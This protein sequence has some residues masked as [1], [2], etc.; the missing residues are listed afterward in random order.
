MKRISFFLVLFFMLVLYSSS[1]GATLLLKATWTINTES[2]MA[3]YNL[4]RTDGTRTKIN[5]TLIAHPPVLPYNFSVTVPDNSQGT[6]TFV[7]T[8]VDTGQNES[9]DSNT[10]PFVYDVLKPAKPVGLGVTK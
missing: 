4:Y 8:A 6:L 10:A 1:F 5:T 3:G 9:E 7:L 2:D